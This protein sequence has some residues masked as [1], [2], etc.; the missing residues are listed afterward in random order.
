M[1]NSLAR[2]VK[3]SLILFCTCAWLFSSF[4]VWKLIEHPLTSQQY[5]VHAIESF[6]STLFQNKTR[7]DGWTDKRKK[8][9]RKRMRK[10]II[11]FV[12]FVLFIQKKN[13]KTYKDK[14]KQSKEGR[15]IGRRVK[16]SNV[17]TKRKKG[18]SSLMFWI[19]E[20]EYRLPTLYCCFFTLMKKCEG[21]QTE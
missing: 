19:T 9:R 17:L 8:E 2:Q 3:F 6:C 20:C 14:Y 10:R 7:P 1:S 5:T 12:P 21:R 18:M 13:T 11:Q 15:L 4:Y 16:W